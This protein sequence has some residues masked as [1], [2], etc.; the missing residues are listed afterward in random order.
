[1][2]G[3]ML[4]FAGVSAATVPGAP[5]IGTATQTGA[6]TATVAYTAPANNGGSVITSYTALSTPAGGSGT[7][8]QAGS[9][10]ISV[11]GL[12][13]GTSY[14]FKVK[15]TNAIGTGA[16][17]AASNSITTPAVPGQC[18]FTTAGTYSWVAPAGITS[19]SA[20]VVGGGGGVVQDLCA[21]FTGGAGGGGGELRYKN[22]SISVTPG[23]SYTVVVGCRGQNT[24]SSGTSSYFVGVG[25]LKANGGAG[26]SSFGTAGGAGGS[27][28]VGTGGGNGGTGGNAFCTGCGGGGGGGAGGYAGAGG[29][30]GNN[31]GNAGSAGAGGGGGGGGGGAVGGG[32]AAG[33]AG[34]GVGILGQ[35]CNGAGGAVLPAAQPFRGGGGSGG[36]GGG[37]QNACGGCYGGG[38]AWTYFTSSAGKGGTAAVRIIWAGTGAGCVARSFPSTNTG[39][40]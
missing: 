13:G 9:G 8:S 19:V 28:G 20:V 27:G 3:M 33:G 14:T 38:G 23:C 39:D 36:T 4:N 25:T 2:S 11:T 32:T 7:L 26:I 1:M 16:E 40:L 17:S 10:T 15:A 5:T 24:G 35:G 30:G 21:P 34:G 18:A 37:Q 31:G 12:S 6:T 29:N 22:N